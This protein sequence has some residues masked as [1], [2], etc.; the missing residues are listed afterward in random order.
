MT[1]TLTPAQL[2]QMSASQSQKETTYN[3]AMLRV[4]TYVAGVISATTTAPPS[5]PGKGDAYIVPPDAVGPWALHL[6]E[7]AI[8]ASGWRYLLPFAGATLY[9]RDQAASFRYTEE[10]PEG[11]YVAGELATAA[12]AVVFEPAVPGD[13]ADPPIEVET[14]L[15]ELAQR[16]TVVEGLAKVFLPVACGDETTPATAGAGKVTFH[17]PCD[18]LV[19]AIWAGLTIPQASG[20][21][22]TVDVNNNGSTMLSTKVTIDNT[23]ETS[24]TASTP[25]V[26][27]NTT[28]VRGQKATVDFDQVGDGSAAGLK[29]YIEILPS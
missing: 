11:W 4:G 26:L 18:G 24:L 16:L 5:T 10:S 19:S 14:A 23:E 6:N 12:D 20:S 3:E 22:F 15:N 25:A 7:I 29:V 17:W 1:E 2:P 8:W 9:V 27:T 28:V 21:L 13:W